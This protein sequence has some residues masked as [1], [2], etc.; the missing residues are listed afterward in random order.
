MFSAAAIRARRVRNGAIGAAMVLA[1]VVGV[2]P[3]NAVAVEALAPDAEPF[4]DVSVGSVDLARAQAGAVAANGPDAS[5][6]LSFN[7][8]AMRSVL[9][10]APDNSRGGGSLTIDLPA[11]DGSMMSF[12]VWESAVMAPELAAAFPEITTYAGQGV[13]DPAATIVFDVTP[14]GFHAQVLSPSGAWYID[15]A[16]LGDAVVHESFFRSDRGSPE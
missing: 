4:V 7:R 6:G 8:A 12:N 1:S 15:P 10:D 14:H 13:D 5:R 2:A 16:A 9:A 3:G 11:P